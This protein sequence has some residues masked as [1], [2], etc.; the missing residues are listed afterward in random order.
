M[1]YICNIS[2]VIYSSNSVLTSNSVFRSDGLG[3]IGGIFF[4]EDIYVTWSSL[5]DTKLKQL[6]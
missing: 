2:Y 4:P 1:I 5:F 6:N 3:A